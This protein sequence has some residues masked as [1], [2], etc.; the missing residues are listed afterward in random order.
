M[1]FPALRS[2]APW[3]ARSDGGTVAG[4][5]YHILVMGTV[6]AYLTGL[7]TA[8][9]FR[10]LW[11][12]PQYAAVFLG[13]CPVFAAIGLIPGLQVSLATIAQWG[14]LAWIVMLCCA[15]AILGVVAWHARHALRALPRRE[16]LAYLASRLAV[17]FAF[18]GMWFLYKVSRPG[19]KGLEEMHLHHWAIGFL[20]AIWGAFNH[21]LSATL[22]AVGT[23]IFVQARP[24]C[25]V[26]SFGLIW[27][28]HC[29]R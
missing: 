15:F 13:T 21:P 4:D 19:R 10:W 26:A 2:R 29:A 28:T 11:R 5:L 9:R 24:S 8:A 1:C 18:F 27:R 25:A 3:P 7:H 12:R 20:I 22:L 23:G 6:L 16:R 17:C 14:P